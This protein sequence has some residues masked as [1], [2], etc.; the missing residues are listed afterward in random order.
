MCSRQLHNCCNQDVSPGQRI[1]RWL[2]RLII[3]L[4]I[5]VALGMGLLHLGRFAEHGR[6][7]LEYRYALDGQEGTLLYEARL[8]QAG[9][10]LYQPL[11]PDRVV[12]APYPPVHYL[13][14]AALEQLTNPQGHFYPATQKPIFLAGRLLSLSATLT[15]ATLL[16]LSVWRLGRCLPVG[17]IAAWIWLAF[18][19]VQLWAT[20]IKPDPLA[21]TFTATGLFA[22]AWY[23]TSSPCG[24]AAHGRHEK[25]V[26]RGDRP[27]APTYRQDVAEQSSSGYVHISQSGAASERAPW[28]ARRMHLLIVAAVVFTLAFFTK[29]TAVAAAAATGLTL[30]LVGLLNV[31]DDHHDRVDA[32]PA[33]RWHTSLQ[34]LRA[35]APTHFAPLLI[36]TLTYLLLV[37]GIWFSLDLATDGQFT[38]HVWGLHPSDWWTFGRFQR[39]AR[40]LLIAWPLMLVALAGLFFAGWQVSKRTTRTLV[41][42]PL[43]FCLS[44]GLL[45]SLTIVGAGTTGS[46]HNHLLEPL[47]A[48]TLAAGSVTALAVRRLCEHL[49]VWRFLAGLMGLGLLVLQLWIV[50]ERPDW[51]AGEFDLRDTY[52]ERFVAL[53]MTQ[54]GEVLADDVGLLLAAGRPLRYD[55]PAT[56]GPAVRVGLWNQHNLLNE[57]ANQQFDL[58]ILPFDATK[59]DIDPSGR[60]TPEFLAVLRTQYR[61]LYRDRLFSYIPKE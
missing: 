20:R 23:L 11:Q 43:I 52:G 48:L 39:Y 1:L 21:L 15:I 25:K 45:G 12:A 6:A 40:L 56:M 19:P 26:C 8:V 22:V 13:A 9:T 18:P 2:P 3:A 14:L 58:I 61:I 32:K 38:F 31:L 37:A 49:S 16:A 46:H 5:V 29:Q 50:C 55:D 36:F 60:W 42:A 35:T 51:Y 54:P 7:T 28:F 27:V 30:L 33:Y 47:L 41:P 10:P 34:H 59:F 4:C 57:V 44:Y 17:I 53:I 24:W